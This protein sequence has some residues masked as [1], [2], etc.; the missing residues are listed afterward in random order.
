MT[1]SIFEERWTHRPEGQALCA[2]INGDRGWLMFLRSEGDAGMSSRD[3]AYVGAP[4]AEMEFQLTNGQVDRYPVAW[5]LPIQDI[6]RAI[7]FFKAYGEPA[8]FV[9]WHDD[10]AKL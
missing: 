3:P 1:R 10:S 2:L 8:P 6:E 9:S 7:E 4:D 5:T